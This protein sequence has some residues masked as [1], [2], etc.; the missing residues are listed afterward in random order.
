[1]PRIN[2][3]VEAIRLGAIPAGLLANRE[4]SEYLSADA[5]GSLIP[6]DLRILLYDPQTAGGLLIS[7]VADSANALLASLRDA[8]LNAVA[9]GSL[10]G[11]YMP[12]QETPQ[13]SLR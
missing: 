12:G 8:G 1:M 6:D 11:P 9:I 2:G 7:V 10:L 5:E 13:F 3:A 4:F